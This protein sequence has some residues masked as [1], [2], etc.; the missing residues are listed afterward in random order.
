MKKI[1]EKIENLQLLDFREQIRLI[2]SDDVEL[3]KN[4]LDYSYDPFDCEAQIVLV[5]IGNFDMVNAY[6]DRFDLCAE[7]AVALVR[8]K[9]VE[10]ILSYINGANFCPE[11]EIEL[12]KFG[13]EELIK[14]YYKSY[15]FCDEAELEFIKLG[16]IEW[17]KTFWR[18]IF[19]VL[20]PKLSLLS[21]EMIVL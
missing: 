17:I 18:I 8:G 7:A 10:L 12:I 15:E 4:Y 9:N 6:T 16:N 21:W 2:V 14:S 5:R 19:F 20:R 13:N 3:L 11:A 1:K